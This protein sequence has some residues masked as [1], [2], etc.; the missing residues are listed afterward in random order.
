MINRRSFLKTTALA[1]TAIVLPLDAF[2]SEIFKNETINFGLIADIHKDVI[3][4]ADERLK[5]FLDASNK[6]DLD[7]IIQMG[8]FA[9][10][11]K[12]NQPF[13][14]LWNSY[15]GDKYHVLGNHD[16]RDMGFT[17][18]QTMT[19]WK[20]KERY[21]SF[22]KKGIH[23]I[24]LDGNDP[25]P[26]PWSGYDRYIG[27]KQ[28]EWL[29]Q[30]LEST[31]YPTIIFSHQTLQLKSD[32]VAN[33]EEIRAILEK[34]NKNAGFNKVMC[35]ISGHTHTDY[36]TKI[37]GI[38]YVQINSASYRWVGGKYKTIRYSNEID[39]KFKNIKYTIPYKDPLFTFIRIKHNSIHIKA[40]KTKY[41]GPGPEEL[42][43][44]KK[45]EG[46]EISS[47]ISGFKMK[48]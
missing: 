44:P 2:S 10:P 12:Q 6:K 14:D 27:E 24:V 29:I 47:R 18:E 11:R 13:L 40:S 36:M 41:V 4:D 46:E 23:F 9:L 1:G 21:Y 3:H 48:I 5:A 15:Q 25:N 19:W 43:I 20:M 35:C 39:E 17:K 34:T 32:G 16:M 33:M 31:S 26:K 42:G 37:N 38:Y 22:D 30:D 45:Q 28:K 8:D 7:F